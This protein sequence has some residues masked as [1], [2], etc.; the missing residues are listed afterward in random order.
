MHT[1]NA[2]R[3]AW[4]DSARDVPLKDECARRG[5]KL[6]KIASNEWAGKCPVCGGD[7]RFAINTL[8]KVF[9]CRVCAKG[10]DVIELAMHIDNSKFDEA[11]EKLSGK[12]PPNKEANAQR[13]NGHDKSAKAGT[14]KEIVATYKYTDQDGK[15]LFTVV[16]RQWRLPDG[17]FVLGKRGK[18]EKDF[19]QRRPA[20]DGEPVQVWGLG[21]GEYMRRSSATD[22]GVF[23]EQRWNK[24]PPAARERKTFPALDETARRTPYQ[25][26]NL[27]ASLKADRTIPILIVEGEGKVDALAKLGIVAT[28][29]AEGSGKWTGNHAEPLRG[30][31][32]VIAA[33]NDD[34][35]RKHLDVVA[36]SLVGI[37]AHVRVVELP[38]LPPKG[39]II[40]WLAKGGTREEL[41][42]LID[43]APAWKPTTS[44]AVAVTVDGATFEEVSKDGK[45]NATCANARAA[46]AALGI[47]CQYDRFHDK[48]LVRGHVIGQH[49]G[50]FS[51]H[52]CL[53]L[54]RLIFETWK[55]DPGRNH[56]FDAC[57]QLC[58]QHSFDPIVDYLDALQWDGIKRI[59][60]WMCDYLGA[61]NTE[62][63]RTISRLT[64]LAMVRRPRKPGCKFD[65]II[66]LEGHEGKLKSTALTILAGAEENFSDQTILGLSDQQQQERLRGKWVFEI[67]DLSGI[68]KAEVESVKAFASRTHDRA[69]PAYGRQLIELPRRCVIFGTT[70]DSTYLKSRTGN[71]RFWPVKTG[72]IDIESLRRDRDQLL[73]EACTV[74]AAGGSLTL[75]VT[76]WGNAKAVQDERLE[77]DPWIDKLESLQ[78][79]L[80]DRADG[81]GQ[82][83]RVSGDEILSQRL[84][85]P[86][87]RQTDTI[88]KRLAFVMRDLGWEGPDRM[89]IGTG[90]PKRGYRRAAGPTRS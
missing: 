15:E 77:H 57:V 2:D 72:T 25:L 13:G 59:D 29:C 11:V 74:E 37:A 82:E 5:I 50:E 53:I 33:D 62:L 44:P 9:N 45:P 23:D 51:D 86:A 49:T 71:R 32:V 63:N 54:R 84:N 14:K 80:C 3:Q 27:V 42:D 10:G 81:R 12:P 52:A 66:V 41:A 88:S 69:R 56:T 8:K 16:R 43:E 73:A 75:P 68:R 19:G 78:G 85:I 55:F 61:D 28:C 87:E 79:T 67:G 76:L 24:L 21:A 7:D 38:D 31:D 47:E 58:L 22:W 4:I 64:L 40:D 36:R 35:G 46:I 39:D 20:P 1:A 17:S 83:E 34:S 89:R 70:N 90:A 18:P 48:L 6:K 65:Q 30:A 26:P 60:T